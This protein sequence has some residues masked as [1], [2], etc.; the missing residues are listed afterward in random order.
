MPQARGWRPW[1]LGNCMEVVAAC[2]ASRPQS[3]LGAISVLSSNVDNTEMPTSKEIHPRS[4]R[5]HSPLWGHPVVTVST[6]LCGHSVCTS[7]CARCWLASFSRLRVPRAI[8]GRS[9][10]TRPLLHH[11]HYFSLL[12]CSPVSV[13]FVLLCVCVCVFHLF[14]KKERED[15]LFER[16]SYRKVTHL[17]VP[18]PHGHDNRLE[19]GA[20]SR[21]PT[22]VAGSCT[23][24]GA[25]GTGTSAHV[26]YCCNR[27]WR[28]PQCRP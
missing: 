17:L 14:K 18:P 23:R 6:T 9:R 26:G 10:P 12:T 15:H 22:W 7:S 24:N 11:I 16:Q 28:M 8:R 4:H 5:A 27:P 25:S 19:Q 20:S 21:S 13:C 2:Q 3:L 1:T